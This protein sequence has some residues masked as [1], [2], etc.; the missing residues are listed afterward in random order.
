MRRFPVI[1][2]ALPVVI[3]AQAPTPIIRTTTT[4]VQLDLVVRDKKARVV[5]D[6]KPEEIQVLEDGVPQEL[7]HFEFY[8]GKSLG[9]SGEDRSPATP[10]A[11]ARTPAPA[12]SVNAL[13]DVSIVTLVIGNLDPT[14][15]KTTRDAVRE[16]LKNEVLP[17]T[18]VGVY[19]L[20]A[21][22]Y[23]LAALAPYNNDPDRISAAVER[24]VMA[25]K[26]ETVYDSGFEPPQP[27]TPPVGALAPSSGQASAS[28]ASASP[29]SAAQAGVAEAIELAMSANWMTEYLD[30]YDRSTR[31]LAAIWQIV[32]TQ[33]GLPGR[34]V[35]LMFMAG[36]EV[37][38]EAVEAL[39]GSIS[40]ANRSNVTIYAVDPT[41][42]LAPD[43]T[44]G[45]RLLKGAADASRQQQLAKVN[46]GDQTVTPAQ[47][48]APD[49][50]ARSVRADTRG[51]L[52]VLAEATGGKLLANGSDLREP[53]R[54]AMEETRTHYELTYAPTNSDSDG[55][56]RKI[57]VKVARPGVAV[58]ARNGY[59]A[60]PVLAGREVYPFEVATLKALNQRPL[61]R[62][63]DFH[64]DALRF[65]PGRERSQ[66][67]YVFQV[68]VRNLTVT[69]D[70]QSASVHVSVT[71]L[72][73]GADGQVVD[74]I[75]KDI[76]YRMPASKAA[77]LGHGVVTFSTP[78]QLAPG[79]YTIETAA[80]DRDSMKSAVRRSVLV[81]GAAPSGLAVS[82][83]ALVRRIDALTERE[84]RADPF[85]AHGAKMEPEM[86]DT[87]LT[88]GGEIRFYAVAYPPVPVEGTVQVVLELARNDEVVLR[89]QAVEAAAEPDGAVP[90]LIAVPA[91]KL[92]PGQYSAR[93]IFSYHGQAVQSEAVVTVEA[94][95][96][97]PPSQ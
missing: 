63:F 24:A 65:R 54:R 50:A 3:L 57:A 49:N 12:L 19:A 77:E 94:G 88:S 32:K 82:D 20:L 64:T 89:S 9:N 17:N 59:Y 6:L 16:F 26:T 72:V 73:R 37:H 53:L 56:F 25:T 67:A 1:L 4:E 90:V 68:P 78:L 96:V 31:Q 15:R 83:V 80:I 2:F 66:Y 91:V 11:E 38:P 70:K 62:D 30:A 79:R 60:L 33:A 41:G 85:Q 75:S 8:D 18:Y 44:Q 21:P 48:L 69:R 28:Q 29:A 46:G 52:R 22:D 35:V 27:L 76:P 84:N 10:V 97:A 45:R 92:P 36:L 95:E 86:S 23:T 34:K 87:V 42:Y 93:L 58:F 5:R 40:A 13:R 55:R 43:L 39:Y 51:N 81:V 7:R 47:V 14:G 61:P 71:A 74:R